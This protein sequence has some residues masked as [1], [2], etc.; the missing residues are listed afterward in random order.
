MAPTLS[1]TVRRPFPGGFALDLALELP[2]APPPVVVLFGPSGAGKSTLLR[3]IAGLD[4][5]AAGHITFAGAP[6]F[7]AAAGVHV[8]PERR[9]APVVF[10]HPALFPH[11]SVRENIGFSP[12]SPRGAALDAHLARFGLLPLAH[13]APGGLSGGQAQRVALARALAAG[14]R[15]LLLDEPLSA[16]DTPLRRQLHATLRAALVDAA[17]PALLVTHDRDEA[18]AL[19]D[20]LVLLDAGRVRQQGPVAATFAAPATARAATL[21]GWEN[22]LPDGAGRALAVRAHALH[23]GPAPAGTR[24]FPGR[25]HSA[26]PADTGH[27]VTLDTGLQLHLPPG[28]APAPGTPLAPW[29]HAADIRALP[30]DRCEQGSSSGDGGLRPP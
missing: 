2:L 19:G 10:Q 20:T 28:P 30:D 8:P 23:A 12:A 26:L 14:P 25:V 7:D 16:L 1:L 11:L 4:R 17:V 29:A 6:W 27:R 5:P 3:C 15:L 21:L 18:L 9:A 13:R 24:T 22:V